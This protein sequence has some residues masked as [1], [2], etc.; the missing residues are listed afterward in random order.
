MSEP[1]T[2]YMMTNEEWLSFRRKKL[3]ESEKDVLIYLRTLDPFGDRSLSL[4][5]RGIAKELE[6]NPSS[7]SRALKRLDQLG[8]IDIELIKVK[9]SIKSLGSQNTSGSVAPTQQLNE[10]LRGQEAECV[11]AFESAST[12][13]QMRPRNSDSPEPLPQAESGTPHTLKTLKTLKTLSEE[14][15]KSERENLESSLNQ[16]SQE[17]EPLIE[18]IGKQNKTARNPRAYALKCL[19]TDRQFWDEAYRQS[20]KSKERA[21]VPAA[22]RPVEKAFVDMNPQEQAAYKATIAQNR[23]RSG[24]DPAFTKAFDII[25]QAALNPTP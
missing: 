15:I 4:S 22:A 3:T 25:A 16:P 19:N 10:L 12:H 11:D 8:L 24:G 18:W 14:P 13:S 20:Q 23:P 2:F 5:V 1:K 17:D 21:I 6:Y 7:V 9:V